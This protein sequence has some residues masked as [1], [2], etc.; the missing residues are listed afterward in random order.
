[1]DKIQ[2][3]GTHGVRT[4]AVLLYANPNHNP[5]L[6]IWPFNPKTM[7]YNSRISQSHSLYQVWNTLGHLF[8]R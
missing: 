1:M 8:L 4:H 7:S 6:D 5:N 3:E 2:L